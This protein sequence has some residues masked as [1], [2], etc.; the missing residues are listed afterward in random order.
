MWCAINYIINEYTFWLVFHIGLKLK[1]PW[2]RSVL[3]WCFGALC[4]GAWVWE[5]GRLSLSRHDATWCPIPDYIERRY[6]PR[7]MCHDMFTNWGLYWCYARP[8]G[9]NVPSLWRKRLFWNYIR[10][11]HRSLVVS[12]RRDTLHRGE[13]NANLYIHPHGCGRLKKNRT[14]SICFDVEL[15]NRSKI[16]YLNYRI[17]IIIVV[18]FF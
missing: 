1:Q 11:G 16:C 15:A 9:S 7:D 8:T 5:D 4:T 10:S 6:I 14:L 12:G 17:K 2:G 18:W 13:L 3:L